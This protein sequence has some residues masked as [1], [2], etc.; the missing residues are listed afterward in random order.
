MTPSPPS[1]SAATVAR[2]LNNTH[3]AA[4]LYKLE[5][6]WEA[7]YLLTLK[8]AWMGDNRMPNSKDASIAKAKAG[9]TATDITLKCVE[10]CLYLAGMIATIQLSSRPKGV[11]CA[12]TGH[13][14]RSS[15][16][17]QFPAARQDLA[18]GVHK[19]LPHTRNDLR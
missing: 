11:S 6:E 18:T 13:Q 12:A 4:T 19:V 2:A 7:A 10:L 1:R 9:R 8:A 14:Q 15:W 5:A 3:A 17:H 16:I